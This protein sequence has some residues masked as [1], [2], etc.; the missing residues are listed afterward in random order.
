[1]K[2]ILLEKNRNLGNIGDIVNVKPGFGRNYL[3]PQK[4]AASATP[5]NLAKFEAQRAEFERLAKE[6]IAAAQARADLIAN[7]TITIS[8]KT[9]E[10][11]RLFGSIGTSDVAKAIVDTC[12]V[13]IARGEVKMPHGAIRQTGE[14]SIDVHLH[15]DVI[16]AVKVNVVPEV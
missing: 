12:A 8:A 1:M 10:E 4:K 9:G 2:V 15:G 11:G 5:A 3:I 14:Y 6:A 7:K 16:V 13:K